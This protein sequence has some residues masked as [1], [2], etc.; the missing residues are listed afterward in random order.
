MRGSV[1][2]KRR[3]DDT[4]TPSSPPTMSSNLCSRISR[5]STPPS[6]TGTYLAPFSES[7]IPSPF[8]RQKT[9]QLLY[10][11]AKLWNIVRRQHGIMVLLY[12][13]ETKQPISEADSVRTLACRG[14]VGLAR[15]EE[16]R[17]MLAKLPL[18]TKALLQCKLMCVSINYHVKKK[19]FCIGWFNGRMF[20]NHTHVV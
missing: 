12:H 4:L 8:G 19:Y 7:Y 5:P 13:L 17:S 6:Q 18:F 9:T 1:N 16:V 15:S 14:L 2:R 3:H 20:T 10:R 11:Q